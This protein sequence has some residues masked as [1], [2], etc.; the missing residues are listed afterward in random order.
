MTATDDAQIWSDWSAYFRP[1]DQLTLTEKLVSELG[2]ADLIKPSVYGSIGERTENSWTVH[3]PA[4]R[5][6][7]MPHGIGSAAEAFTEIPGARSDTRSH[8]FA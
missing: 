2:Q 5:I 1:S 4:G 7:S 6:R 3:T 8:V